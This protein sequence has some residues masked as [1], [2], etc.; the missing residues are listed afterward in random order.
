ML[1]PTGGPW[2]FWC[3]A[4]I[5]IAIYS[6]FTNRHLNKAYRDAFPSR[7]TSDWITQHCP[8]AYG[9]MRRAENIHQHPSK[10]YL[11]SPVSTLFRYGGREDKFL[12]EKMY[13]GLILLISN[14]LKGIIFQNKNYRFLPS[15]RTGKKE[16]VLCQKEFLTT[17]KNVLSSKLVCWGNFEKIS[18]TKNGGNLSSGTSGWTW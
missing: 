5:S 12:K 15:R 14:V 8:T 11:P 13:G 10:T 1:C 16:G 18:Q 2:V 4:C 17:S 6:A 7:F 9:V 3:L